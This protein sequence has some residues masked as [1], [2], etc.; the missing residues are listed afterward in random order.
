ME[1]TQQQLDELTTEAYNSGYEDGKTFYYG[2]TKADDQR[3]L[4]MAKNII[5]NMEESPDYEQTWIDFWRDLCT[6]G[7]AEL[8]LDQIKRELHDYRTLLQNIPLVYDEIT[9]GQI[10]KPNTDPVFV[11][12]AVDE[13][14]KEQYNEGYEEG[15]KDGYEDGLERG[16][17]LNGPLPIL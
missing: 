4:N 15:L 11:I 8:N 10:S 5:D 2:R 12:A 1:I 7:N 13:R 3:I 17:N 6:Y 9:G 16:M 14:L